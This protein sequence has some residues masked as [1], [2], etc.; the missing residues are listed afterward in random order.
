MLKALKE[1]KEYTIT[2]EQKPVYLDDGFDIYEDGELIEHS[3]K[4]KIEYGKYATVKKEL[5]K[6]KK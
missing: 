3:P 2:E 4:K 5:E 1:N 6:V